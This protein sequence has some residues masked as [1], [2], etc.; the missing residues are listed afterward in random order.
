MDLSTI[1]KKEIQVFKWAFQGIEVM[2]EFV[3]ITNVLLCSY[4]N[5][6]LIYLMP[7]FLPNVFLPAISK[8]VIFFVLPFSLPTKGHGPASSPIFHK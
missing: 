6:T 1:W 8:V 2:S 5:F 3:E 4:N 7:F